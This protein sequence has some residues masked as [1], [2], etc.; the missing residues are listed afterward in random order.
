MCDCCDFIA[1]RGGRPDDPVLVA[2]WE[3]K[4]RAETRAR[5]E[6]DGWSVQSVDTQPALTY[7][8]GLW[9]RGHA[10]LVLFG[11][12]PRV[13]QDVLNGLAG[14]V[15]R[16]ALTLVDGERVGGEQWGGWEFAAFRLPNPAEVIRR[17][18]TYYRRP[19]RRSVPALQL[20]YPDVHGVWPWEPGCHLPA[21]G[22][23]LPGTFA[24]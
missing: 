19:A 16:G 5:I 9:S 12:E 18:N 11:Q 15:H 2:E 7:T 14:Q 20:V 17:A 6:L 21:F 23:P 10:E 24:S 1:A 4:W 22:Q 13:A 8:I 3:R